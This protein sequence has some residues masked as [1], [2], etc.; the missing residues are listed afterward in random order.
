[1]T[2]EKEF[3]VE[4]SSVGIFHHF[5]PPFI[6]CGIMFSLTL[7]ILIS[8]SVRVRCDLAMRQNSKYDFRFLEYFQLLVPKNIS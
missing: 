3:V 4:Q 6:P 8:L 2:E 7:H 5:L 1:M